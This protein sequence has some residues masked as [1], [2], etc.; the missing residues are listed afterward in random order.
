MNIGNPPSWR[1]ALLALKL[2]RGVTVSVSDEEIMRAKRIIDSSG[3]GC[4]P[5][6]AATVAG[7]KK[8]RAGGL[9]DPE[10]TAAA[11]LTGH[12]LK[13]VDALEEMYGEEMLHLGDEPLSPKSVRD[14]L[15]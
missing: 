7:L 15:P 13:D 6:S 14:R 5:A 9:I 11:I 12:I 4:E 3:V 8:L 2:T 1:K 10:E